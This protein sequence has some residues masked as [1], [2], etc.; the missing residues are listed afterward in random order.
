MF[1]KAILF[2]MDGVVLDSEKLY[3]RAEIKLFKEYGIE[4]PEE[5]WDL[6]RGC[7]ENE[8]FNKTM[9]RYNIKEDKSIF[10]NKGRAYV[11]N[12]FKN[13]LDYMH[14]F[15]SLHKMVI[16]SYKT[17]LVT[18]SPK[19]NLDWVR[20]IINLDYYFENI[21]SGEE[22]SKNKPFPEPYLEMMSRLS[23]KPHNTVIVEDSLNGIQAALE[24][25]AFVI[26]KTGSVPLNKLSIA[27]KVVY[28]LNEITKD[29][30]EELLQKN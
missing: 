11:R 18:A 7:S 29:F 23:V 19:H 12:E 5:D 9:S 20:T 25:G 27:H 30:I 22:T 26:A 13:N 21:L 24:S 6:F 17:A 16:K 2:D 10:M 8:F 28:S 3:T 4:I 1:N 15:K 14:G